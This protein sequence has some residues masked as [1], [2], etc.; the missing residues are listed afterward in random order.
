VVALVRAFDEASAVTAGGRAESL[1]DALKA[2]D[3]QAQVQVGEAFGRL[4]DIEA[5]FSEASRA[6]G[7]V[8]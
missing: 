2:M 6:V 7:L 8:V 1:A 3:A 4:V 5:A